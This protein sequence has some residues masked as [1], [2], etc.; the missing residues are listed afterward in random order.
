MNIS[1]QEIPRALLSGLILAGISSGPVFAVVA[2]RE[3]P[4]IFDTAY[5]FQVFGSLLLV[6]GCLFGLAF[7]MRKFNGMPISDRK[8]IQIVGSAKVGTREKI[9]LLKAGEL[10]LLVGVAAGSVRTLHV[11]DNG[12]KPE[13]GA[14]ALSSDDFATVLQSSSALEPAS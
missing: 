1:L 11:F 7:L 13:L 2:E 4:E 3:A 12:S 14:K 9:V 8:V 6:F 5:L 10:E